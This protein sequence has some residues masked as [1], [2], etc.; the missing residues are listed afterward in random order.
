MIVALYLC[1]AIIFYVYLGYPLWLLLLKKINSKSVNKKTPEV[2]PRISVIIA[3]HNEEANIEN[4]LKNILLQDYPANKLEIIVVSDG[5]ADKTVELAEAI[6]AAESEKIIHVLDVKE[7]RGKPASIN[8]GVDHA[9]GDI[10]IFTDARQDFAENSISELV[11]NFTDTDVGCVSGELFFKQSRDS[12]IQ[13]EMGVYWKYE[14]FIRKSE[15]ATGSVVGVTGAIYAIRK[16]LFKK[17][18]ADTLID[19]VLIPMQVVRQGSRVIFDDQAAAY[20]I[21]SDD[22]SQ[23]WKRKVRTLSGNW[24]LLL[25]HKYLLNPFQNPL[26]FEFLS[27]KVLRLVVPFLMVAVLVLSYILIDEG[28]LWLFVLQLI[29]YM[30]FLGGMFFPGLRKNRIINLIYFFNI[31]NLAVVVSFYKMVIRRQTNLWQAAYKS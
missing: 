11:S 31:L 20:D 28:Y 27:H 24:Q 14:K 8:S 22:T 23:E 2:W 21:V 4:R 6:A 25:D 16:E 12:N 7:N 26:F 5:S 15:S 3:A 9:S 19:D 18:P 1:L 13:K 10:L 29:F 30:L 17:I